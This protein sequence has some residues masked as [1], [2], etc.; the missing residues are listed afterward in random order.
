[1]GN[2]AAVY[3]YDP[4]GVPRGPAN[5]LSQ[6]MQFSTKPYDDKTGLSYYGYRF[7]A[8]ALSR[9]M[10][11]DP[12]GERGGINLYGFVDN[13]PINYVD[14]DGRVIVIAA[15]PVAYY[16]LW[17][18]VG[19]SV[20]T[21]ALLNSPPAQQMYTD[22]GNTLGPLF[23]PLFS[24]PLYPD[25]PDNARD[26]FKRKGRK[27]ARQCKDD[28]SIWEKD[29]SGHG[30]PQWKRWPDEKSWENDEKPQ[31]IWPDGRIRK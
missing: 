6:P 28:G 27:G 24:E 3:Q 5:T 10:T 11:R 15:I 16:Y 2:V 25:N 26:K 14:P 4:F 31:S 1:V 21:I 19:L 7:Y 12:I 23:E 18:G 8:P 29:H 30:G 17:G 13:N 20:A 22:I 9:W